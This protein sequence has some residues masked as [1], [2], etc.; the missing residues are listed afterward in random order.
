MAGVVA[1]VVAIT[2]LPTIVMPSI[3]EITAIA[4]N[5]TTG[6]YAGHKEAAAAARSGSAPSR[7]SSAVA[8]S[9]RGWRQEE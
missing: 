9:S 6:N 4:A 3:K 2:V 5:D 7:S 8:P 1:T